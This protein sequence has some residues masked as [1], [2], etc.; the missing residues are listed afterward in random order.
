MFT[1]GQGGEQMLTPSTHFSNVYCE[2]M[3]GMETRPRLPGAPRGLEGTVWRQSR[4]PSRHAL[5]TDTN[6]ESR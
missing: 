6:N 4:W 1:P 3:E 5:V 2:G